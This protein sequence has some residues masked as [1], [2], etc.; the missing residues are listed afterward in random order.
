MPA[1]PRRPRRCWSCDRRTAA[2]PSTAHATP[3]GR[4]WGTH[5]HGLFHNDGFRRAWLASL[6]W[7]SSGGEMP[8]L[9]RKAAGYD[10]L[11]DA[12]EAAL[13]M[14]RLDAIIGL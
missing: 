11:A 9:A 7:R 3:D 1:R 8:Y 2:A 6:G 10:R 4:V 12:L 13:D 5:L 14:R